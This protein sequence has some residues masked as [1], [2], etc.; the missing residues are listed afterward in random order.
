METRCAPASRASSRVARPPGG[1]YILRTDLIRRNLRPAVVGGAGRAGR[2]ARQPRRPARA[3]LAR[4]AGAKAMSR[5]AAPASRH[6]RAGPAPFDLEFFNGLGG[7]AGRARV[8]HLARRWRAHAGAVDQRHRQPALRLPGGGGGRRLQL[9]RQQPREPADAVVQRPGHRPAGEAMYLQR[10]G[11]GR[12]VGSDAAPS[13]TPSP[14]PRATV[15]ATAVR[16]RPARVAL[17]PAGLRPAGGSGPHLAPAVARTAPA[18]RRRLSVTAYVEWVLGPDRSAGAPHI[19]TRARCRDRRHL[20]PQSLE[21]AL[22]LPR[23]LRRPRRPAHSL[24]GGPA[25][26]HRPPRHPGGARRTRWSSPLSGGWGRAWIPA[27]PAAERELEPWRTAEVD[28][29]LGEAAD[30]GLAGT[31][32]ALPARPT[33]TRCSAS[34]HDHWDGVLD[35]VQVKTPDRSLDIMLNR[36]LLY[37]SLACRV[38]AR[39]AFYQASGAYGFRDQLQDGMALATPGPISPA[40]TCCG[41]RRGSSLAGDVQHWWLPHTGQG[42]ARD[43][44]RRGLARLRLLRTT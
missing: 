2:Q 43:L 38:W 44:R 26:V 25:G 12:P 41:R 27:R 5:R 16:A 11:H 15:R 13:A 34:V 23:R 22:R 30:A 32:R 4:A 7:F 42:C 31:G 24:D 36:W 28:F 17:G 39:S 37:Q 10:R 8:R 29:F 18:S 21:R 14:T 40:N 6:G 33:S 19:T 1:V 35:T 3:A 9:G 20:R